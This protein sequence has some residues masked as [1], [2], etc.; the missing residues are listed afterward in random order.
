M[1]IETKYNQRPWDK[2]NNYHS[3]KLFRTEYWTVEVSYR[4]HTPG[5]YIIFLN[6]FI[7]RFSQLSES[8]VRQLPQVM[9]V[10]EELIKKHPALQPELYNYLQL[11]NKVPHFHIHG[12]PRYSKPT[13]FVGKGW[14]DSSYGAPPVWTQMVSSH[15]EVAHI[16]RELLR[17]I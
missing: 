16:R 3:G 15:E 5:S 8:E 14:T 4:Q 17:D 1:K 9:E 2:E 6:R 12:I 7:T 13:T 11:G 10:I